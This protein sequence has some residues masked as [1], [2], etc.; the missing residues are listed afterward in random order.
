MGNKLSLR[1]YAAKKKKI[2][3]HLAARKREATKSQHLPTV[4]NLNCRSIIKKTDELQQLLDDS[5]YNSPEYYVISG[6]RSK[7]DE[8]M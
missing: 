6:R 2:R 3:A 1:T 4:L 5:K 7:S 8:Q